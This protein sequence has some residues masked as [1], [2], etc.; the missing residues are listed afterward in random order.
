MVSGDKELKIQMSQQCREYGETASMSSGSTE[1]REA[2]GGLRMVEEKEERL[3][4]GREPTI[5]CLEPFCRKDES[6]KKRKWSGKDSGI[7]HSF[8]HCDR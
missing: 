4:P 6:V 5:S 8:D 7:V 3:R 1:G 2:T